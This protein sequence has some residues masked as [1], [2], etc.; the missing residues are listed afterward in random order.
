MA[1]FDNTAQFT[2][3]GLSETANYRSLGGREDNVTAGIESQTSKI[4]SSDYLGAALGYGCFGC[5]E[6]V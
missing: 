6:P 1:S 5:A 3:G 2:S 4:P